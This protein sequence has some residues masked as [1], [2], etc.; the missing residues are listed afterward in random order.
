VAPD[1][2]TFIQWS[3]I[4]L[5]SQGSRFRTHSL[6]VNDQW[7]VSQRVS[8]SLGLRWDRNQGADSS[9]QVVARDGAWSPRLGLVYDPAGDGRWSVT[10]S[11]G[12]YVAAIANSIADGSSPAGNPQTSLFTYLGPGINAPGTTNLTPTPDAIR[13]VFDWFFANGGASRPT[14]GPPTVPGITPQIRDS[15][16]SPGAWEYAGGVTRQFGARATLRADGTYRRF[17]NFYAERTDRSTGT[18]RDPFGRA[19]DLTLIENAPAVAERQ[20]A[21]L[22]LQ[23][24]YRLGTVVD[25]GGNYTLSRTWGNFDGES[26]NSGPTRFNGFSY[27]EY[28]QAA[29][30][31]PSGDL[32]L[33]QR[34]RA[35]L[36]INYR[37]SRLQGLTLSL[38]QAVESGVPY[39]AVAGNGVNPAPYVVNPGYLTPPSA[40]QT[41]YYFGPRD[42]FRTE[43]SAGRTWVCSTSTE[44]PVPAARSSSGNCRC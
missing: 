25:V 12:R 4:P 1:G 13:A 39:G 35:R 41:A 23:G 16:G 10:G 43:G 9:G 5:D 22:T 44:C 33:D 15:L 21:G 42:E 20:Y 7:R 31:Y 3:P 30:N 11:V 8:A 17:G 37:P 34:H 32:S 2:S 24:T 6:F 19:Y 27:P 18:V 36:W 28:K 40:A 14:L 26:L 38:L 29:W